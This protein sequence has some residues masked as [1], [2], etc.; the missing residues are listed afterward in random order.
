ML[1]DSKMRPAFDCTI[2]SGDRVCAKCMRGCVVALDSQAK[3][4]C[5]RRGAMRQ[6]AFN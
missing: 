6:R 1:L 5:E 3:F 4:V 2:R